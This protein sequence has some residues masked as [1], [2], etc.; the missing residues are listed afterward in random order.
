MK[1]RTL[2]VAIASLFATAAIAQD[3][4]TP[5]ADTTTV[6]GSVGLGG[7]FNNTSSKDKARMEMYRDL[8]NGG[9]ANVDV[10]VRSDRSWLDLFGENIGRRDQFMDIRGGMYGL[11]KYGA[12]LNDIP[13]NEG[14]NL[15][16][17]YSG[18]GTSVLTAPTTGTGANMTF[19]TNTA[20]WNP[21]NLN[22][23]RRHTGAFFEWNQ[24]GQPFY[25]R[26]DATEQKRDGLRIQGAANGTSPGNG[27]TELPVP[28]DYRT[29]LVSGE[30]GYSSKQVLVSVNYSQS[31]F[32]NANEIVQF[33]SAYFAGAMDNYTQAPDST[34]KKWSINALVKNLF[35]DSQLAMR[36]TDSK[37]TAD[38]PLLTGILETGNS[39][40]LQP[41]PANTSSFNGEHKVTT[42]SVTWTARPTNV[43][44]TKVYW[45]YYKRDNSSGQ[46]V[47]SNQPV[48][49]CGSGTGTTC[50]PDLFDFTKRNAGIEGWYRFTPL[51]KLI[52]GYDWTETKREREDYDKTTDDKVYIEG[53]SDSWDY[54]ALRLRYQ[55]TKRR[56][57]FQLLNSGISAND[58]AYIDRY[59]NRFDVAPADQNLLKLTGDFTTPLPMLDLG[60][61]FYLKHNDYKDTV[62]GRTKDDR[63]EL[64]LNAAYGPKDVWRVNGFMDFERISYD[65]IHRNIGSVSNGPTPPSGF[66]PTT[67]PNCFDPVNGPSNSNSYNWTAKER[68]R[69]FSAGVA[70]DWF[71]NERLTL[72]ASYTFQKTDGTVDLASPIFPAPFV[73]LVSVP[74]LDNVNINTVWLRGVYKATPWLDVTVGYAYEHYTLDDTQYANYAYTVAG[75][76]ASQRSY[77]TGYNGF[78]NYNTNVVYILFTYRFRY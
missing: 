45:N 38:T 58:P 52:V 56:S 78:P 54:A 53:R 40:V 23:D 55:Y 18:V 26:V 7:I 32:T 44:D 19:N 15:I 30:V 67:N 73:P 72:K 37:L 25:A 36:F 47:F 2:A 46:V 51:N 35:W 48:D 34:Q 50:I 65:S 22:I 8:E 16:T 76:N 66:C 74:Q 39:S 60:G 29:T 61:E 57:D 13:H 24:A 20:Q 5:P 68:Q 14:F 1:A 33:T 4:G 28:I 59:V 63:Q 62:L 27:F 42:N 41:T 6:N 77:L 43:I 64:Y 10:G 21:F 12:S 49:S 69:N 75:G 70:G 31:K 11:F 3:A 71:F 9:I 17:P